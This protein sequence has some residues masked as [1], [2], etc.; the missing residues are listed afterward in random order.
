MKIV[1]AVEG[2]ISLIGFCLLTASLSAF[3][4]KCMDSGM[5]LRRYY[6]Y[7][8][9]KWIKWRK[10]RRKRQILKPLGLCIYCYSA[11]VYL[12]SYA[13]IKGPELKMILGLGINYIIIEAWLNYQKKVS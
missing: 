9:L 13:A 10:K 2:V 7:L 6:L 3:I 8:T 12:I 11:W 1:V 5:I 4:H